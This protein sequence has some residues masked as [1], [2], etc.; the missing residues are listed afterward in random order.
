MKQLFFLRLRHE[1][2]LVYRSVELGSAGWNPK[3]YKN[4]ECVEKQK[5]NQAGTC[6]GNVLRMLPRLVQNELQR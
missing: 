6:H 1:Q 4:S 5:R 2:L 3:A